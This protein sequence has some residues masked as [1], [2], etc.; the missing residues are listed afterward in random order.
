MGEIKC[1]LSFFTEISCFHVKFK[2]YLNFNLIHY[3]YNKTFN[4]SQKTV[5][6]HLKSVSVTRVPKIF[7]TLILATITPG[8][9]L[10]GASINQTN[11]K[12]T[13]A[14]LI[15]PSLLARREWSIHFIICCIK[16]YEL[17]I[18]L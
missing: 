17:Q 12:R 1:T 11:W 13:E 7:V 10:N 15:R 3:H 6:V 16:P 14:V 4:Y 2:Y 9:L 8:A 5:R 18:I